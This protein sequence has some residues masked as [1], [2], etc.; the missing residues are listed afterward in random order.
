MCKLLAESGYQVHVVDD[1]ST[2]HVEAVRWGSLHVGDIDN[3]PFMEGVFDQ[4]QP[5]A[6]FHFAAKSIVPES[7][8]NPELYYRSNVSST[9][10]LLQHVR[11]RS[12]CAFIF[13]S[14]A[15]IFGVPSGP[16]ISESDPKHPIN[17]YGR[18]KL[19]VEQILND[20]WGAYA[21]PSV[22][23]RYFN[24]A[25]ADASALIGES[26]NP[27]THL[28]PLLL[29][30]AL[31]RANKIKL[32]GTDYE[33]PDGTCVRDF[34]HVTDLCRAHLAGYE[35]L[36]STPG[37]YQYNLGN[38]RGFSVKDVIKTAENVLGREIPYEVAP[39][40]P[41]DPSHLVANSSKAMLELG[42][43][44]A[45]PSLADIIHSAWQW[46]SNKRF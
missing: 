9:V 39:R 34:I 46:H 40:R 22:C 11:R 31:G 43:T 13:S 15:A 2:G 44:P 37:A 32:Y 17:V 19:M 14:T 7:T 5:D 24:A 3:V 35:F 45:I 6:V 1:L 28:I 29:E 16:T 8:S 10:N 25:G 26:H 20:Y 36:K 41:G 12:G 23:F 30:S 4:C 27:E 38:G 21:M 18:S 33:T 42:W